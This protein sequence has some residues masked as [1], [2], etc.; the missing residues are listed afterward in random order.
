LIADFHKLVNEIIS[1]DDTPFIYERIGNRY[2]H[3]L[4]D[5]FQDTS[6]LQWINAVPLI[7]NALASNN[8]SLIV[9][10]AKQAIYRWRG[11]DVEQFI[12]L[13]NI[14]NAQQMPEAQAS[15]KL[16]YNPGELKVNRRSAKSIVAFNN[17]IY[18]HIAGNL[19]RYQSVYANAS[20]E[21][22]KDM[23]GL[24]QVRYIVG[25]YPRD[26]WPATSEAILKAIQESSQAGYAYGDMTILV[27]RG[28][29]AA[30]VAQ[31]LAE[32]GISA[33]TRDSFL[34]QNSTSVRA[35]THYLEYLINPEMK[36]SAVLC[37]T[38][39]AQIHAHIHLED[40][41]H[42][43]VHY[44]K[45]NIQ[46]RFYDFIHDKFGEVPTRFAES[47]PFDLF[48]NIIR[49]F[50]LP[51]NSGLEFLLEHAKQRCVV[52]NESIQEFVDWWRDNQS[53]LSTI[54]SKNPDAVNIMT[55][56]KSK[57]LQFPVVIYPRFG[58]IPKTNEIWAATNGLSDG[59][60]VTRVN[61]TNGL[62]EN[63][64]I[65]DSIQDELDRNLLDEINLCYVA[66]TRAEERLY[67]IQEKCS[68][69]G[70]GCFIKAIEHLMPEF[71]NSESYLSG[72]AESKRVKGEMESNDPLVLDFPNTNREGVQLRI[73]G[74][75]ESSDSVLEGNAVHDI[76]GRYQ[77]HA[78]LT[79]LVIER[80]KKFGIHDQL[81]I[82]KIQQTVESVLDMP[83]V[84]EWMTSGKSE[85]EREICCTDG[86]ILRPD[87][88]VVLENLVQVIDYKT[89]ARK[90]DH[91][92]QVQKYCETIQSMFNKPVEG[93]L[94][95]TKELS[96][97]SVV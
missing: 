11:G 96:I 73:V 24:V 46:L 10:D 6:A 18:D 14:P 54:E 62:S 15:L 89:G 23:D 45:R 81:R 52:A 59:L 17:A 92:K 76:L 64:F 97:E 21:Q 5:E 95:Y 57:G 60:P 9:G 87:R 4:F 84:K 34:V 77:S 8:M 78:D 22:H 80:C 75:H 53:K 68:F 85:V 39:L 51:S 30:K 94:L 42:D 66:T 41:M 88:I 32:L 63:R 35:L 48:W 12:S 65:G 27:R 69:P 28:K 74:L 56:H 37:I 91:K 44:E 31:Y 2:N 67:I 20:Q 90:E 25:T 61:A 16:Q 93:Y 71:K 36:S 38:A 82:G 7:H 86:K 47:N 49:I 26:R 58:G 13:P 33:V 70:S 79:P 40:F 1:I 29:E 19:G 72:T 55:V 83:K 43:Y 50:K 3:I